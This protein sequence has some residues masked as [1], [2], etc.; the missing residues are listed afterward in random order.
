SYAVV[1]AYIAKNGSFTNAG[2]AYL[3]ERSGTSWTQLAI[4]AQSD[5]VAN[6]QLGFSIG[7]SGNFIIAGA[8]YGD[9]GGTDRGE[10]YIFS[11]NPFYNGNV[12]QTVSSNSTISFDEGN[13]NTANV[14]EDTGMDIAF[15]GVTNSADIQC[16]SFPEAPTGTDGITGTVN[17]TRWVIT[18]AG[19]AFTNAQIRIDMNTLPFT[20][21]NPSAAVIY[22][23]STPGSGSF[24]GLA[25]TVEGDELV[26]NT[27]SF[28][29]FVIGGGDTPLAIELDSF[30]ARQIEN[31]IQLSW[32]TAS[33]TENEGFNVYRKTGNGEFIKISSFKGNSELEGALNSTV[34]NNYSFVDN[35]EFRNGKTY[36]YFISDVETNGIETKHEEVAQTVKFVLGEEIVQSKLDYVL[37]QNFP[38][39]FNPSTTINF[40]I[41]K[42]QTVKLEVYNLNG[43]IVKEL[44]NEKM[45]QGSHKAVWNGTDN[46][47]KTVSSGTYFY[48]ISAGTFTQ[49]NKMILLK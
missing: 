40:Q 41:A 13:A 47:G 26:A 29:E 46:F 45:S 23:R 10:A 48:K 27:P 19:L 17:P 14:D 3:Y 2:A 44:V 22:H 30:N 15:T 38:N 39:P 42:E 6:D 8:R 34:S 32:T 7:L 5:P 33:E 4:Y 36:T 12:T 49:T 9:A 24:T 1:G 16:E 20:L 28:S 43:E 18:D 11:R 31:S 25:T 35:S 37:A 21:T